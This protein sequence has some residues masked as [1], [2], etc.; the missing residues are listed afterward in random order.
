MWGREGL[1]EEGKKTPCFGGGGDRLEQEGQG[2]ALPAPE[3]QE[4]PLEGWG[5]LLVSFL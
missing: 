5:F 4:W 2:T 1:R 3:S